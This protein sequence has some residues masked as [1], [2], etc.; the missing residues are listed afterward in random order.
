MEVSAFAEDGVTDTGQLL[1]WLRANEDKP[2][3]F[4]LLPLLLLPMPNTRQTCSEQHAGSA[5]RTQRFRAWSDQFMDVTFATSLVILLILQIY[6]YRHTYIHT[7]IH[8]WHSLS[9]QARYRANIHTY[10]QTNI[11]TYIHKQVYVCM[12]ACIYI[13]V[14][15]HAYTHTYRCLHIHTTSLLCFIMFAPKS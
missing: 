11:H 9:R 13:Y 8:V 7:Y 14:Y 1:N 10:I 3:A 2:V 15:I 5:S 6:T 4:V 12:Y